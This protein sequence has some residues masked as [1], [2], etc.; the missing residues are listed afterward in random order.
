MTIEPKQ[1]SAVRLQDALRLAVAGNL[2]MGPYGHVTEAR[3]T[4]HL[5]RISHELLQRFRFRFAVGVD[6]MEGCPSL[7]RGVTEQH[8]ASSA[9]II[10]W[11]APR[12]SFESKKE[13]KKGTSLGKDLRSSSRASA[14]LLRLL[15]PALS[16]GRLNWIWRLFPGLSLVSTHDSVSA[17]LRSCL[18]GLSA[19][20]TFMLESCIDCN[21]ALF[22]DRAVIEADKQ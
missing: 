4:L 18:D 12:R 17:M 2:S 3:N 5:L 19:A 1:S 16:L 8:N 22:Q 9:S 7:S 13:E 11:V 6:T 20:P 10:A 21:T 14:V 15:W